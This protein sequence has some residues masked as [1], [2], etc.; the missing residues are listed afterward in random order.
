[1]PD[2][3]SNPPFRFKQFEIKQD[4]CAMKVGTDGVL[5]GS[6]ANIRNARTILDI[7]S[8][9]GLIALMLAQRQP[10]GRIVGVE[11]DP[12]ACKQAQE[13]AAASPF[14]DRLELVEAAIQ[15]FSKEDSRKFDLIVSNPPFFSGGAL[16]FSQDRNSV[17]HTIKLSHGDLLR[18]VQYLLAPEGRFCLILPLLEGLRFQEIAETYHLYTS[19]ITE[20]IPIKGKL[21]ERLLLEFR[22]EVSECTVDQLIIR[23]K[24]NADW[25]EAFWSLTKAFYL[26]R[27]KGSG[28]HTAA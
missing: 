11:I 6:W 16:S 10:K 3:T 7:G 26:E 17:R 21:V 2:S 23:N 4:R 24:T 5:L 18:A 12:E 27:E 28:G 20:V 1:M 22:R 19:S 8:G 13:N 25:S 9:T 14:S 15:D